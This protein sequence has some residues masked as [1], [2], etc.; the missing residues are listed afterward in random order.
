M[1]IT[2][3]TDS[4][5]NPRVARS[6]QTEPAHYLP[7]AKG[8]LSFVPRRAVETG[9]LSTKGG[10]LRV[11]GDTPLRLLTYLIDIDP[12]LGYAVWNDLRLSSP[13]GGLQIIGVKPKK[14]K[15][16]D[17][18]EN[19]EATGAIEELFNK[20]PNEIGGLQGLQNTLTLSAL[21]SGMT[22]LEAVPGKRGEGIRRLWP[23]DTLTIRMD[24]EEPD[25][26][27]VPYQMQRYPN[28]TKGSKSNYVRLNT[29]LIQWRLMDNLADD[30]YGRAP[31]ATAI[32]EVLRS[33]AM[34][35]DLTNAIHN[36]GTPRLGIPFNFKETYE[37]AQMFGIT[38]KVEAQKWVM[39]EF[40]ATVA[41]YNQLNPGENIHYDASG[42]VIVIEGGKGLTALNA[43]LIFLRQRLT[44]AVK[45]LPTLLGIND[46]STQ[47][48]T[49]V[50]WAIYA[51][52]LES[53]RAIV[54]PLLEW[55]GTLHLRL[56]G[57]P[58]VAK[59]KVQPIRVTD[60]L[61]EANTEAVKIKNAAE[62]RRQ[63]FITPDQ[64]AQEITGT[65]AVAP[66]PDDSGEESDGGS[67]TGARPLPGAGTSDEERD[68]ADDAEEETDD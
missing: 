13:V 28:A 32:G 23:V 9:F 11:A 19:D 57:M 40:A 20:L 35:Q 10:L 58:Y 26:D 24:R 36:A 67:G 5:A 8:G 30:L 48:Y 7:N 29:D 21:L 44:Q 27:A 47:T 49:S 56:L 33:L 16:G 39:D 68:A 54:I 17:E 18:E 25:L 51:A 1:P 52:G 46:G 41:A 65:D 50:E 14:G 15:K 43:I 3:D 12:T 4:R 53:L 66:P 62:K 31:K 34:M 22:M 38:D 37:I 42:S 6:R 55:A 2:P 45:S 64:A 59:A 60:A 63:G 61:L